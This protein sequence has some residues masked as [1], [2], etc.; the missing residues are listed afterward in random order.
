MEKNKIIYLKLNNTFIS[1]FSY[2]FN[3]G[4]NVNVKAKSKLQL[5]SGIKFIYIKR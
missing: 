4:L 1:T 3:N 2:A 5:M